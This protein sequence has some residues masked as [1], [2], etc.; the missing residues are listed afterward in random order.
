MVRKSAAVASVEVAGMDMRIIACPV[1]S[2]RM[3]ATGP[4]ARGRTEGTP[5][6]CV[7]MGSSCLRFQCVVLSQSLVCRVE[8]DTRD[9][10]AIPLIEAAPMLCGGLTVFAPLIHN[11]C[12][13]GKQVAVAG[14][15][16]LGH[17]AVQFA[18]ALGGE[19]WAL[20]HSPKKRSD[21]LQV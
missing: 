16:G 19:V 11:G 20:S 6:L 14:I 13:P 9:K 17:Y 18:A 5:T 2:T 7:R 21:A 12:G 10:D 1:S 4:M 3:T 15:G 8:T